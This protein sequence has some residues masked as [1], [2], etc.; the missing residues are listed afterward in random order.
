VGGDGDLDN[1]VLEA[2]GGFGPIA[3]SITL[4]VVAVLVL[5]GSGR[6]V[7]GTGAAGLSVGV[8]KGGTVHVRGSAFADEPS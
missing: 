4:K 5:S 2:T 8:L 1:D 7:S 3:F 6:N